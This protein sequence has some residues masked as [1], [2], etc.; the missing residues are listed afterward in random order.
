MMAAARID[1]PLPNRVMYALLSRI[2]QR[3]RSYIFTNQNHGYGLHQAAQLNCKR[4]TT[5]VRV[6][7]LFF[8][9]G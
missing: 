9:L 8:F 5:V 1:P 4:Y 7:A 2:T 6:L 3:I